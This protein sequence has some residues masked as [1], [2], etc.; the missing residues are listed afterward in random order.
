MSNIFIVYG[1]EDAK[2]TTT[3]RIVVQNI[4]ETVHDP[5]HCTM[6]QKYQTVP[7]NS[8]CTFCKSFGHNE[9]D[10]R[11][12]ELMWERTSDAYR[13]YEEMMTE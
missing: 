1:D 8:Y 7:N 6:M 5:Y 13:V 10:Y 3:G 2:P 12:M 11:T 4:Q 9:K